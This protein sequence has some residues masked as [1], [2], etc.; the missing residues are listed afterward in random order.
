MLEMPLH[1]FRVCFVFA[2]AMAGGLTKSA[3]L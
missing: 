2:T 1:L 3:W